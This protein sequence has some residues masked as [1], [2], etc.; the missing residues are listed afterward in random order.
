MLSLKKAIAILFLI[1]FVF[2]RTEAAELLK[3]P[4]LIHHYLEHHEEDNAVSFVDFLHQH[5]HEHA[6]HPSA[7]HEH[8]KLPFKSHDLGFLQTSFVCE[9]ATFLIPEIVI[10]L[11]TRRN[12]SFKSTFFSSPFLS[13]IWQ[14][15]KSS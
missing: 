6:A 4:L 8:E 11:P 1:L 12:S 3:L 7:N 13:L 5:Y 14:P 9:R 2:A 10:Q 15:P